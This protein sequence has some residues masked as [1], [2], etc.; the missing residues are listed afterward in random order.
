MTS[1]MQ[2]KRARTVMLLEDRVENRTVST[3]GVVAWPCNM[4]S[5]AAA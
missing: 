3:F 2:Y 4:R 5:L 1:D